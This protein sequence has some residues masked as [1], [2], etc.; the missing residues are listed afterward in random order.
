MTSK[1]LVFIL[2]LLSF[3][4]KGQDFRID[5]LLNELDNSERFDQRYVDLVNELSFEYLKSDPLKAP[6]YINL[7]ISVA[8]EIDYKA[9]LI[10]ATTNKGSSYMVNG[11]Q[12]EALSYYLLSLSYGAENFPLEYARINNNIGEVFKKKLLFDSA[13]KYYRNALTMVKRRLPNQSPVILSSNVGETFLLQ[14]QIDS[15]EFYYDQTLTN[16]LKVKNERGLAYAYYGFGEIAFNRF[17]IEKAEEYQLKALELR[18]KINDTRGIIQSY[19]QLGIYEIH[20]GKMSEAFEYWSKAEEL[21]VSFRALDLLND[22]YLSKSKYLYRLERYKEAAEYISEYASLSDSIKAEEFGSSLNRTKTALLSEISDAENKFL[23]QQQLREKEENRIAILYIIGLGSIV[24]ALLIIIRFYRKRKAS[25]LEINREGEINDSLL[26]LSHQV[27]LR[28]SDYDKFITDFLTETGNLLKAYRASYWYLDNQTQNLIC[29]RLIESGKLIEI[30][31]TVSK[32]TSPLFF[33]ELQAQR[34]LAV[35][36]AKNDPRCVD[37]DH[38]YIKKASI[39]SFLAAPMILNDQYIGF[40]NYSMKEEK[41]DWSFSD[42][43]Y[44]GSLAD[45]LVSALA[46][47]QN[48]ALERE[49]ELLIDKLIKKNK[50]LKEFNS[51]I[52]HNLREP[53]TQIIGFSNLLGE[54][55]DFSSQESK[56]IVARLSSSSDKLD[57]VIRDLSTILNEQDPTQKDFKSVSIVKI[58]NEVIEALSSEI[59]KQNPIIHKDF[60]IRK[61]NSYQPLVFDIIYHLLSNSLKFNNPEKRL[62]L[63]ISTY[64]DDEN[65]YLRFSDNGRGIDLKSFKDRIFKMYMRQHVDIEGRGIGLYIVKNRVESLNGRIDVKSKLMQG[66]TFTV[67]LPKNGLS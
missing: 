39:N 24:F 46:N 19:H 5:S 12:D 42:Q 55:W 8:K 56:E 11:L 14:G 48:L 43:R 6:Y 40:I 4:V 54:N 36:D 18:L 50:S 59:K 63:N 37:I 33:K 31:T 17:N 1:H 28:Q 38:E 3:Y 52:S 61:I 60:A 2:L 64:S 58:I 62:E 21:A 66:S 57:T 32:D 22:I 16:S 29:Y 15:A 20:N 45:I 47:N 51:V 67:S 41:R 10:R 25:L 49:K 35:S 30:N 44:V 65:Y 34:T 23:K 7:S 27:N 9:G 13:K 26:N 53:L